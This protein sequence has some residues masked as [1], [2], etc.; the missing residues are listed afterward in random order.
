MLRNVVRLG[1]RATVQEMSQQHAELESRLAA[2]EGWQ[3]ALEHRNTDR[4]S[5]V[6]ERCSLDSLFPVS[7]LLLLLCK[8]LLL[9]C[10]GVFLLAAF[11]E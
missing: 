11:S 3:K 9:V 4:G 5:G 10:L 2:V 8:L 6:G 7:G 1:E